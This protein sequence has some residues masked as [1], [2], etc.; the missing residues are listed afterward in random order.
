MI[1]WRDG[2][3]P[4]AVELSTFEVD[5]GHVC[6]R[7]DNPAGVLAGVEFTV[8][9]E[10]GFG[11]SGRDQLDDHPIADEWLGTPVLAD[12]GEEAVLNLVPLAG[13]GRQV[14]DRNVEVEL[15]GQRLPFAFPQPPRG[16]IAAAS[17]GGDQQSGY[18]GIASPTDGEPP[19]A[20]AI[21]GEGGR[22]MVDADTYPSGIGGKV[23]DT[24]GHRTT[25]FLDQVVMDANLFRIAL[26]TILA[27]RIAEIPTSSFFLVSTE[28]AGCCSAKAAATWVLIW[29]NWASRSGWLSLPC[30]L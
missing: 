8:H 27:A 29:A 28:I 12:E 9:R 25:E 30:R 11:G 22:V 7:Y 6:I 13:A 19:L 26:R 23:I 3:V 1:V 5:G 20:D 21:D 16:A 15:V 4:L 10:A 14:A 18:F 24:I 17:I 2:V